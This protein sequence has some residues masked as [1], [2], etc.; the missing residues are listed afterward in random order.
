MGFLRGGF[1]VRKLGCEGFKFMNGLV[2]FCGCG[3]WEWIYVGFCGIS[4]LF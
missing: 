3:L 1:S 2:L 4:L